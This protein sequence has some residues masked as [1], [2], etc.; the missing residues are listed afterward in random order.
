MADTVRFSLS[1]VSKAINRPSITIA[2]VLIGIGLGLMRYPF[3]R[4]LQPIGEFYLALLQMCVLPFLLATIPLAVR[5]ALTS[6]MGG[7]VIGRLLIWL[8]VTLL[9]VSLIAIL[10]SKVIFG[11]MPLDQDITNRI[12]TLL[13]ATTDRMDV[14]LALNPQLATGTTT[15]RETG[16]LALVPTNIFSALTSN[17]ILL[18]VVFAVIFG[19]GMVLTERQSEVSVFSV[20]RHVQTA[21][22]VMFDWFNVIAPIGIVSLIAPQVALLGPDIYAVLAPFIYAYFL[23]TALLVVVPI[24]VVATVLRLKPRIAL[25]KFLKPLAFA[26]ATR[27]T[28]VCVPAAL[29]TMKDELRAPPQPCDLY[30]PIGFAVMRFGHIIHFA[31]AALFLGYLMGRPFSGIDLVLVAIYSIMVSFATIGLSGIAGLAPMAAVLRPF[32]LSYELALPL[33]AIVDPIASMGRAMANVALNC[34]IPVLAAGRRSLTAAP[35]AASV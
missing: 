31:T 12:G 5:S 32:G 3:L 13:G 10:V 8:A 16:L 29:E 30:I 21:C 28:L 34:Q 35:V 18:V 19:I 15:A 23:T 17:D 11:L 20:L 2:A 24:L 1:N 33:M 4:Y 22:I 7:R 9:A 27:N 6:G 14:E 25:E 26:A